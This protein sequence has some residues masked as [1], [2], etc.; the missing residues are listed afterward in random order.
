MVLWLS[1]RELVQTVAGVAAASGLSIAGLSGGSASTPTPTP[2]PAPTPTPTPTPTPSPTP[3]TPEPPA[4]TEPTPAMLRGGD[5]GPAVLQLQQRLSALGY[6]LGTPDGSFGAAT[7]AAVV[8]LQKV[9]GLFRDGVC[10]PATMAHVEAGTRPA[11]RSA[12]GHHVE[13]DVSRQVLM[14]VDGGQARTILATSTGSGAK[15]QMGDNGPW[16]TAVTP[17]GS[18]Q[19]FRQVDTWD[20]SP[21]GALYRPKYFNGG[22]A[23]HG[24][25]VVPTEP[26]SHGCCRVS[27]GAMDM[28]WASGAVPIGTTVLVY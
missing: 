4:T 7:T 25:P 26:A 5:S 24:F 27:I 15:F 23:I 17:P 19:V 16:Y 12:G 6:W 21:L 8:A 20:K 22:I 10:G 3:S 2:T 13:I 18:F 11:A 9:A 1:R 28:L 14:L